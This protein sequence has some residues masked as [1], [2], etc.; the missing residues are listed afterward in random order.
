M[1]LSLPRRSSRILS[2]P[3]R[4]TNASWHRQ[5]S[6]IFCLWVFNKLTAVIYCL[7]HSTLRAGTTTCCYYGTL[8][9][10]STLEL[11]QHCK[12]AGQRAF[13][14]KICMDRHG[15]ED[16][17]EASAE[18]SLVETNRYLDNF[19]ASEIVK[20]ILTPRFAICCDEP[21]LEGLGALMAANKDLACQTWVSFTMILLMKAFRLTKDITQ[22]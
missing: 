19:P 4:F 17:V 11:A 8:H 3:A 21:L 16:Y 20:P 2:M 7:L 13:V 12:S 18:H 5:A 9:T 10:D 1:S 22:S 14:G 6:P 15:G